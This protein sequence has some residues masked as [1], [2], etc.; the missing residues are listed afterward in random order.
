[1]NNKALT[2][3]TLL[4]LLLPASA[5]WAGT[6]SYTYTGGPLS[7]SKGPA[8]T[9]QTLED[10]AHRAAQQERALR[11]QDEPDSLTE[12]VVHAKGETVKERKAREKRGEEDPA[13]KQSSLP[14]TIYGDHV[15]YDSET[16]DFTA[17]GTV[18]M[19]QGD[20]KLYTTEAR[21]NA[22]TG[23]VYLLEGGRMIDS[24]STNDSK[25]GHYN[26]KTKTGT[27]KDIHGTNGAD[28]YSAN[29]GEI[30]PDRV[31]LSDGGRTTRCP[32]VKHTP[33]AEV[34]ADKVV[35]Y[36]NDKIIAYNVKVYLKGKHIYSRDRWIN[37]LNDEGSQQSLAPHIGYDHDQ[38]WKFRFNWVHPFS[39]SNT[40]TGDIKYYSKVGWR[41][42]F[43]DRQDARNF[44]VTLEEGYD[45]DDDNKWIR[46]QRNLKF[47]YK[48]HRIAD[49]LP[50][51]YSGYASH[52]LWKDN[53]HRSWHTEY[54][55][56]L[57]HD[58]IDLTH[59]DRPL[60]LNLGAGHKWIN[61]SARDSTEKTWLYSG[62]L[63]RDMGAGFYTWTG[64]FWERRRA[65]L[66]SY[67]AP[68]MDRELQFGLRKSF[69]SRDHIS[70]LTRYDAGEHNVYEYI[71]R[72][73]HDFCCFR[74][75]IQ[76]RDKRYRG[77]DD[78]WSVTYDLFRW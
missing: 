24:T 73:D 27:V 25:W 66:F 48:D 62:V 3:G 58:P 37:N 70:F 43:T 74:L 30:Y 32:A 68:D 8:Y 12:D 5:A 59:G 23:D 78:E 35:I 60:R 33:C 44:Y 49:G 54:A 7:T 2:L 51:S 19:Y 72:W 20:Q 39:D 53:W 38:G 13:S 42:M 40:L 65:S 57:R 47:V 75:G 77:G 17:V 34:R 22:L 69:G 61:E 15:V 16:G 67:G 56:F 18:R 36:P 64:Y 50:L 28:I 26:F 76:Y 41:P 1:M 9:P 46:K 4:A 71:W 11:L 10:V 6:G 55:A 21:G 52:G 31:E 14:I 45:E 29:I 63:G